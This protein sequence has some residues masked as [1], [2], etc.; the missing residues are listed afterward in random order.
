MVTATPFYGSAD[1]GQALV[2]IV[3]RAHGGTVSF[4][5]PAARVRQFERALARAASRS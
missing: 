3:R 5:V 1:D 2:K 4:H